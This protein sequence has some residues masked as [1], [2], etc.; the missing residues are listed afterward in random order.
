MCLFVQPKNI[1]VVLPDIST[2]NRNI[3]SLFLEF[4][5]LLHTRRLCLVLYIDLL[6]GTL[7]HLTI[8]AMKHYVKFLMRRSTVIYWGTTTL[9]FLAI[10]LQTS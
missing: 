9:I 2:F 6:A 7:Q 10:D 3:E 4:E 8:F 5:F 1:Y